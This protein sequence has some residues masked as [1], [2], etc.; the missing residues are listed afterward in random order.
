[1]HPLSKEPN[2]FWAQHANAANSRSIDVSNAAEWPDHRTTPMSKDFIRVVC[3]SDTHNCL[4]AI[5]DKIPAGDILIHAGD[6]TSRGSPSEIKEFAAQLAKL[7]HKHKLVIAG[8]H[9]MSFDVDEKVRRMYFGAT[10]EDEMRKYKIKDPRELL[11]PF[12]YLEDASVQL[13]GYN[14][15]GSPWQPEYGGWA[16]NVERGRECMAKWN[17][18]PADT[19]VLITHGPP[20]GHGDLAQECIRAGCVDLLNTVEQRVKPM[21]HVFGHIHEG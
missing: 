13:Y 14:F 10:V 9:E 8:N 3:I 4:G 12:H 16:F 18:I 5:R 21:Y 17:A 2:D 7:P 19:D 6:F 1:M 20:V 15:Y 11:K